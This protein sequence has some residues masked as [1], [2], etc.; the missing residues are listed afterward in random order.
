MVNAVIRG[1][2]RLMVTLKEMQCSI[3]QVGESVDMAAIGQTLRV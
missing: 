3:S 2:K 1:V